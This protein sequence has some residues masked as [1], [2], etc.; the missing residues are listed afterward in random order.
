MKETI[1]L[2]FKNSISNSQS[3]FKYI[4]NNLNETGDNFQVTLYK[5][6]LNDSMKDIENSPD[7]ITVSP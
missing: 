1:H 2:I 4:A 5:K 7:I 6:F 3:R